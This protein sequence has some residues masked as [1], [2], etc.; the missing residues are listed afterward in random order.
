MRESLSRRFTELPPR[1][2]S[3]P[4][5]ARMACLQYQAPRFIRV[6]G[7]AAEAG[8]VT[9]GMV[10]GCGMAVALLQSYLGPLARSIR[11][12][13]EGRGPECEPTSTTLP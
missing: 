4:G 11:V 12:Q 10:A 1:T 6:A 9:R 8:S 13:E 3:P 2:V 5:L 7:A